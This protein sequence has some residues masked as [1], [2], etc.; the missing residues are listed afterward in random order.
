MKLVGKVI[1]SLCIILFSF[2]VAQAEIAVYNANNQFIGYL[3]G[4]ST[5]YSDTSLQVYVPSLSRIIDFTGL[6]YD[7]YSFKLYVEYILTLWYAYDCL[8]SPYAS[9]MSGGAS[10][11]RIYVN[12]DKYYV[13]DSVTPTLKTFYSFRGGG[14]ECQSYSSGQTFYAVPMR[15]VS[16]PF[17]LPL[18]EPLQFK[19]ETPRSK[20][21]FQWP[22]DPNNTSTGHY[23]ACSEWPGDP[24]GCYWLGDLEDSNVVWRDVQ[25]FQLHDWGTKG[26]HLGADYNLGSGAYDKGRMVYPAANGI[27]SMVKSNQCGYGNI[28]FVLHNTSFGVYTSMY[29][30]VDWLNGVAPQ[31]GSSVTMDKPIAIVGNGYWNNSACTKQTG[32]WPYHLHFEIREGDNKV[33]GNSYTQSQ[34]EKGPQGQ[35]NPNAFISNHR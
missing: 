1:L 14:I 2:T 4:S 6:T 25:P 23:G 34:V 3:L 13:V 29:A 19:I 21:T 5:A 18:T 16:L 8:G 26:Y 28:I 32:Q 35:I 7:G 24:G 30:H 20:E 15:E 10:N 33:N 9:Y 31:V 17:T 27:I 11:Y 22:V 12:N